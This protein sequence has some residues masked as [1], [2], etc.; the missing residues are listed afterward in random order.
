MF[1]STRITINTTPVDVLSGLSVDCQQFEVHL[2]LEGGVA[3]AVGDSSVDVNTSYRLLT[4][5]L[6]TF[7]FRG[8]EELYVVASGAAALNVLVASV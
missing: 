4:N 5:G 6:H 1:Q 2:R 8:L 7:R 3:A